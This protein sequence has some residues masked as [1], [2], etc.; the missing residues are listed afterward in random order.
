MYQKR[1]FI[2]SAS[3]WLCVVLSV[4]ICQHVLAQQKANIDPSLREQMYNNPDSLFAIGLVL[5]EQVDMDRLEIRFRKQKAD[6]SQRSQ[7]VIQAL[8][9]L[10]HSS[11]ASVLARL[12]TVSGIQIGSIRRL[13]INNVIFLQATYEALDGLIA[14]E[15][16]EYILPNVAVEVE[17]HVDD[18]ISLATVAGVET[19]LKRIQAPAL[20]NM[21][22]TGYGQLVLNIDTGV[23][24]AHPALRD[25]YLGRT[26]PRT[27]AW[28]DADL[29]TTRP[30]YCDDHGTHVLGTIL[31]LDPQGQDTIGVAFGARWIGSPAICDGQ[32]SDNLAAFQ[33]AL[34][35]DGDPATIEDM[36]DVINNSWRARDIMDDC[37][38]PL[39]GP[40]L[41][42]LEAAGIAVVFSAGNAGPDTATITPPKNINH[43]LVNT[44]TVAAVNGL[45]P[46][47][48]VMAFSSRGPSTCPDTGS[49]AIKPEVSAPGFQIRSS[50]QGGVYGRKSGTSMAAPHVSGAL[51]LLKE[52]FPYLTGTSLKEALYFTCQDLGKEGEDND[53]GMG[54]ID[55][56]AAFLYLQN[57]GNVPVAVN[58]DYDPRIVYIHS[59]PQRMCDPVLRPEIELRN[60]G[61]LDLTSLAIQYR[62][63]NGLGGMVQWTGTLTSDS[64]ILIVLPSVSLPAGSHSLEVSIVD[65]NSGKTDY[66]HLDNE[67]SIHFLIIDDELQTNA[68]LHVCEGGEALISASNNGDGSVK[69]YSSANAQQTLFEGDSWLIESPVQSATYYAATFY[70]D[71][72]GD[73]SVEKGIGGY[74]T[75]TEGS[76]IFN[77]WHAFTLR[78]VQVYSQADG[79][80]TIEL[81]NQEGEV[82]TDTSIFL[83]I[84]GHQI[85]LNFDIPRGTDWELGLRDQGNL[86]RHVS[87]ADYPY[88]I[89]GI[90]EIE[91][92]SSGGEAYYYF[93]DWVIEYEKPCDREKVE[94][95]ISPGT[96]SANFG[97]DS[98]DLDLLHQGTISFKDESNQA[99][100]WWWEFGDGT[101][102]RAQ[103][104]IHVYEDTGSYEVKLFALGPDG[105]GDAIVQTYRIDSILT[106]SFHGET[107][108]DILSVFPN[109]FDGLIQ[110]E[111]KA[112]SPIP[113]SITVLDLQGRVI[114][115]TNMSASNKTIDLRNMPDGM[116][117]LHIRQADDLL[118]KKIIKREE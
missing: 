98:S 31:G 48:N 47:L 118:V 110:I 55:V 62:Y 66:H 13:W 76:L 34:N 111:R 82:V 75:N 43:D 102:S 17:R 83:N 52:A 115:E 67:N 114:R 85:E 97:I 56:N 101:M 8:Q 59:V 10:A 25:K 57:Q 113:L 84:G 79:F 45:S 16:I 63:S 109:P 11:Q 14:I 54:L 92:S 30:S 39:Y 19:G 18:P 80:R 78:S 35:P 71:Q 70:Q 95:I 15:A 61:R 37:L 21:G 12:D 117:V 53:Y 72:V 74:S 106:T 90:M 86:F 112:P 44:F 29:G 87:G 33:W 81:K 65:I 93:Y 38:D 50:I 36:P 24:S 108:A 60:E 100:D 4:S 28:F 6:L 22:Y 20:W 51:L 7:T 23:D 40:A 89:P 69:W 73:L 105:C 91:R 99:V 26:V 58:S 96:F 42:A 107:L 103:H 104:P 116:Y 27:E 41:D 88:A 9:Q 68:P 3:Y 32:S 5:R 1:G 77:S 46:D 94:V 2:R 49:L 64:T